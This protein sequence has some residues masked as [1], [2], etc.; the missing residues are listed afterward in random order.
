[1]FFS[2]AKDAVLR[3][4]EALMTDVDPWNWENIGKKIRVGNTANAPNNG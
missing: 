3:E 1:M 2:K 4:Q